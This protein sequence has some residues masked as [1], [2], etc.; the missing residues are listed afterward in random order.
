MVI[1]VQVAPGR[2][3]AFISARLPQE[4]DDAINQQSVFG[5]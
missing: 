5:L 4:L 2:W 3:D 1:E